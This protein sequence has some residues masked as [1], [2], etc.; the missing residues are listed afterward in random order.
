[1]SDSRGS[2]RRTL[3]ERRQ[4]IVEAGLRVALREGVESVSVRAV[5]Q[6]AE[7]SLGTVHYCFE[8]KAEMLRAMGR[9]IALTAS[10]PALAALDQGH[11]PETL[12]EAAATSLLDGLKQNQHMRLLTFEFALAGVRNRVLREVAQGHLDQSYRMTKEYLNRL[13]DRAASR[14][15]VDIDFLSR[16]VAQQIDGIEIGWLVDRDDVVA[17]RAFDELARLVLSYMVPAFDRK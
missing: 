10:E 4:E 6:E 7:I 1:M 17:Q 12:V 9:A 8:D 16:F 2:R 13:A 14:F 11:D 3:D 15:S 5:A